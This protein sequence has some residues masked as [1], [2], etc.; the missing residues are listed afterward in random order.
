MDKEPTSKKRKHEDDYE[1]KDD[2]QRQPRENN[3]GKPPVDNSNQLN[4]KK[5]KRKRKLRNLEKTQLPALQIK[6]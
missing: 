6:K 5:R 3:I 2:S 4:K 1:N